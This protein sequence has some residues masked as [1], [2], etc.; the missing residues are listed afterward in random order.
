MS[1]QLT[2]GW[3][4]PHPGHLKWL[5]VTSFEE[6]MATYFE[7]YNVPRLVTGGKMEDFALAHTRVKEY[8]S[9]RAP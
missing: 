1:D 9:K 7:G 2:D 6:A 8:L 4:I 3:W 5:E